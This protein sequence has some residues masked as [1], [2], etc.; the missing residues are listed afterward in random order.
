[1]AD[2]L[3]AFR[4][5]W[6]SRYWRFA[7][8]RKLQALELRQSPFDRRLGMATLHFDTAGADGNEPALAIPYLP[9]DT[10]RRLYDELARVLE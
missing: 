5:G 10:A 3:V 8:V 6:L 9:V 1:M 7:E 2:G 4:G